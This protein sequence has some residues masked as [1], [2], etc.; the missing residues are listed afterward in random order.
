MNSKRPDRDYYRRLR[1]RA[2]SFGVDLAAKQWC[3]LWHT[4][5]DWKGFGELGWV[6]RRRHLNALLRALDRARTELAT[7]SSP[8]QLF[9]LVHPGSSADDAIYVHTPNPNGSEFPCAFS[10]AAPV[11]ELPPLLVGRVDLSR[12]S[13]L[14]QRYGSEVFYVI[15][16]RA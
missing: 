8:H 16:P 15:Q 1:R 5:F 2:D 4:H 14:L 3:D 9:A 12:Y 7:V 11:S 13:V 6:H 10:N